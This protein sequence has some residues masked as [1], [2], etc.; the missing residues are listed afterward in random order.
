[1]ATQAKG[2]AWA[3]K[4]STNSLIL[5]DSSLTLENEP[6]RMACWVMIPNQRCRVDL[7]MPVCSAMARTL[8]C[9][10]P[11]D[12]E[13]LLILLIADGNRGSRSATR[14]ERSP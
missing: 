11:G 2:L 10:A 4:S 9:V 6:R 3:L 1:M 12:A 7:E 13:Q 5:R 8:Q 14:N